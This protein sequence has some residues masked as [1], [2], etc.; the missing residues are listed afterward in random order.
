MDDKLLPSFCQLMITNS[1]A[2]KEEDEDDE[3]EEEG[4]ED[5]PC[6]YQC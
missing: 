6:P 1:H 2:G 3:E 5:Q 4:E